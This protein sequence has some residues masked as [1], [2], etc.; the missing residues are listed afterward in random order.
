M[1]QFLYFFL[2]LLSLYSCQV[3]TLDTNL[4]VVTIGT[5]PTSLGI[6]SV[7]LTTQNLPDNSRLTLKGTFLLSYTVENNAEVFFDISLLVDNGATVISPHNDIVFLMGSDVHPSVVADFEIVRNGENIILVSGSLIK[8]GSISEGDIRSQI[9]NYPAGL[10]L[11]Q[12][13]FNLTLGGSSQDISDGPTV[14][15]QAFMSS[16]TN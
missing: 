5:S 15:V 2:A 16:V 3:L 10:I 6:T 11:G 13:P 1:K 12:L 9:A 4:T 14:Q 7:D 8:G